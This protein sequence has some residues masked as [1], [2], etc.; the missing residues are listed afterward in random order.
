MK[1]ISLLIVDDEKN[2]REELADLMKKERFLQ[3]AGFRTLNY[4]E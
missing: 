3:Q 2:A 1:K 4:F